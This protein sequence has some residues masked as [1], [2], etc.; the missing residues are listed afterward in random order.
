MLGGGGGMSGMGGLGS[1]LGGQPMAPQMQSIFGG[2]N[3][4][5]QFTRGLGGIADAVFQGLYMRKDY[6][7][8]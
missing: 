5:G 7:K 3:R 2:L 1:M 8:T 6:W 4:F